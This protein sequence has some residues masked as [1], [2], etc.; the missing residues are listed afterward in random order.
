MKKTKKHPVVVS[1]AYP[2]GSRVEARIPLWRAYMIMAD[3][4][5][6]KQ[7]KTSK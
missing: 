2:D 4:E 6:E 7:L 5:R 1:I 3:L